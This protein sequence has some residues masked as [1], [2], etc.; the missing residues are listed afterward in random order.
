ME[1]R[2]FRH[3]LVSDYNS[4]GK[5]KSSRHYTYPFLGNSVLSD[6]SHHKVIKSMLR[7]SF[8]KAENYDISP[9][10]DQFISLLPLRGTVFDIQPLIFRLFL[11]I[12]SEFAFGQAVGSLEDEE[13]GK[14]FQSAWV[15]ALTWVGRRREAGRLAFRY[16]WNRE[17]LDA[18]AII[19]NFVDKNVEIVLQGKKDNV[20]RTL[21]DDLVKDIHDPI[22]L[23]SQILGVFLPAKDTP[24]VM[25]ANS[26]FVLARH[27]KTWIELR[28]IAL[29]AKEPLLYDEL[30]QS[31]FDPIRHTIQETM[32]LHGTGMFQRVA[33][34]D[35]TLPVGGGPN[36]DKPIF[37]E[38]GT[39][40]FLQ[41]WC[42]HHD[43]SIWG[44]D[45]ETFRPSRWEKQGIPADWTW[46]P[47]SAGPRVCPPANQSINH[48][49]FIL[50]VL[51]RRYQKIENHDPVIEY[52]EKWHMI[53]ESRNGVKIAF[54]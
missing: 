46:L 20:R 48:L 2:N 31:I 23:R 36:E 22:E 24:A 10:V 3:A 18:C 14:A 5:P 44:P 51:L 50:V 8:A 32:R 26:L 16:D 15:T 35:A 13:R 45:V 27:P 4:F 37:V 7:P 53:W 6:G 19:H 11:D 47:F 42:M 40:V 49:T 41:S 43:P 38:K 52:I 34:R 30:K 39:K 21:L 25:L 33:K 9:F 12:S 28:T 1:P 17:Y 29:T 54:H